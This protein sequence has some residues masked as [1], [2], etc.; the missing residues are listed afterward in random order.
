MSDNGTFDRDAKRKQGAVQGSSP[1]DTPE[2]V[3]QQ[4]ASAAEE[5]ARR[6]NHNLLNLVRGGWE[7]VGHVVRRD[8][9]TTANPTAL[10]P[11]DQGPLGQVDILEEPDV[12]TADLTR[13][14]T[15]W[16]RRRDVP[17]AILAWAG[18]VFLILWAAGHVTRTII[19]LVIA[20]L[21][22]YALA[23]AVAFLQRFMPRF[24][25]TLLIYLVVL[26]GISALLYFIIR[27][28]VGQIS[29]LSDY[30]VSLLTPNSSGL[31]P[32]AR[33]IQS[34]GI[35]QAQINTVRDQL[36]S[37]TEGVVGSIVPFLTEFFNVILDIILVAILS[38]YL[39]ADGGRVTRWL[40][41]NMPRGQRSRMRFLLNT[42]QRIV[43]G[44]IRGQLL[45]STLIGALVGIGMTIIQVPYALLLGVLAFVLE[46]IPVLG[47]L[48]SGAICVLL[49]LT[50]GW[51]VALIVLIYFVV[52]HIIEGD[53]IGPRIVG[54]AV[55]LHP[56]VSL[57]ALVAGAELFGVWGALFASPVAGVLQAL[58]VALWSEWRE[59]HPQEFQRAKDALAEKVQDNVA[60]T[61]F[62]PDTGKPETASA[63]VGDVDRE[64][65]LLS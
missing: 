51:P 55:G 42:L 56:V 13:D 52:V 45:M 47:T 27:T 16:S 33:T 50:R 57:A 44:Y 24:L 29:Q 7:V 35:S 9:A 11:V 19:V 46:F 17:L 18:V 40:R 1:G 28:T 22:A 4:E 38:I 37:Q 25:A 5:R 61:N 60:N 31:S 32:L 3:S 43:G 21:L 34:F 64:D 48:V 59:T 41:Q 10:A 53:I 65:R 58:I 14:A 15:K 8:P 26:T 39:L 62:D 2:N 54:K 30:V 36:I 23:P 6:Q 49:A 20:A 12:P 63:E